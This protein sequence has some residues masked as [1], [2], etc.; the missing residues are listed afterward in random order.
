MNDRPL[1]SGDSEPPLVLDWPDATPSASLRPGTVQLWAWSLSDDTAAVATLSDDELARADRFHFEKHRRRFINARVGLRALLAAV[2]EVSPDSI[3]FEYACHGKPTIKRSVATDNAGEQLHF[4]LSHSRDMAL[5]AVTLGSEVGTD[6]EAHRPC[7]QALAIAGRHFTTSEAEGHRRLQGDE[8]TDRFF[9]LWSAK[10]AVIKLLG[11][12]LQFPLTAFQ[13]PSAEGGRG[14]VD[15]PGDNPLGI[16][17]C[18][19]EPLA[20]A[21]GCSA[22]LATVEQPAEIV[23]RQVS[24]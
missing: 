8:Q 4:N 13:T 11:S 21:A 2:T 10:E 20:G 1:A 23:A 7:Q 5:L 18:W 24:W 17:R 14:A 9:Q 19:V 3:R 15:L 22:A 6:I 16:A 12:G